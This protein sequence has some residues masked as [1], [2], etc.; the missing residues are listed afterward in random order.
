MATLDDDNVTTRLVNLAID[1]G[2]DIQDQLID[3]TKSL[4]Y[5]LFPKVIGAKKASNHIL[6]YNRPLVIEGGDESDVLEGS[7]DDDVIK[8]SGMCRR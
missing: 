4:A 6:G 3:V 2:E 7:D 5:D 8:G 1:R